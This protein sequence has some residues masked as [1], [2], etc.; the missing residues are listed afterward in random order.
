MTLDATIYTLPKV[1]CHCHILDPARFAYGDDVPYR[2]AG[3][4]TGSADYFAQ[5][6]D[7]YN[8]QHALLVEPNSGYGSMRLPKARAVS[9]ASPWLP[10]TRP[11][12]S[13]RT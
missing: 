7:A 8:A 11:C 10:M 2:P 5:V 6:L 9:R 12:L 3:Q 13:L 4:E 1:D